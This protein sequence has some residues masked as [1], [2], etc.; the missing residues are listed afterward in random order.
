MVGDNEDYYNLV[1]TEF[2]EEKSIE[3][4]TGGQAGIF[5]TKI[6]VNLPKIKNAIDYFLHHEEMDPSLKWEQDS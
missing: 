3:V 1:N 5:K 2:N 4:V 6:V